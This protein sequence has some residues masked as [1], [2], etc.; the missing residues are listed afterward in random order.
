MGFGIVDIGVYLPDQIEEPEVILEKM[1]LGKG[2]F[3]YCVSIID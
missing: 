2:N 3:S 1:G